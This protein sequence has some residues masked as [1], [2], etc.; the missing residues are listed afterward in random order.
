MLIFP[1]LLPVALTS[2]YSCL[3]EHPLLALFFFVG[4]HYNTTLLRAW[5]KKHRLE[6]V[7]DFIKPSFAV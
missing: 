2:Q 6:D 1:Y 5:E 7:R 3:I 4:F